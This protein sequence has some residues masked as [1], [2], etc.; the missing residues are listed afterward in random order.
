MVASNVVFSPDGKGDSDLRAAFREYP[1]EPYAVIERRGIRIGLFGI[2]G[3]DAQTDTP[4]AK[5]VTFADP[6]ETSKKMAALLREKEKVDLVV[7]LSHT[8]T[9]PVKE[10]S[11]DELLARAV[12]GIDVIISGHTHTILPTPIVVGKTVI[13]SAGSYGAYLGRLTLD[14]AKGSGAASAGYELIPVARDIPDDPA[15]AR[16]I[17]GFKEDVDRGYLAAYGYR[18]DQVVAE[19]GFDMETLEAR[20]RPS[21]GDGDRG[22]DHRRLPLRRTEGRGPAVRPYPRGDRAA[23]ADP[24]FPPEGADH[25]GRHLPRPLPRPRDGRHARLPA[26]LLLHHREGPQGPPGGRNHR[27]ET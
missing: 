12:P 13:V 25:R 5:P 14:Y 26:G 23:R 10:H 1:V 19:S 18:Y 4:F 24:G 27:G 3:K 16:R 2:L 11:E 7:C 20:L 21:R 17:S 15:L 9:S 8:G 6:V 22:H